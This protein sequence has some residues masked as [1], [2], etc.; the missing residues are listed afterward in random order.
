MRLKD[1]LFFEEISTTEFAKKLG[2]SFAHMCGIK[3]GTRIAGSRLIKDIEQATG[4]KVKA[5]D[6]QKHKNKK[7]M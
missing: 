5:S 6:F 2:I 1:Y 7:V 4:G 3:N